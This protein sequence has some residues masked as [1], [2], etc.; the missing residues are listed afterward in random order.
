MKVLYSSSVL[1]SVIAIAIAISMINVQSVLETWWK[2]ASIFRGGM[3]GLFLLGLISKKVNNT[4]AVIGVILGLIVIGWMSLSPF[5]FPG[6]IMEKYTSP[7]H[8]YLSIVFG[9]TTI[10]ITGFLAGYILKN[11]SQ[12]L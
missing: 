9:T 11:P 10:F 7:F 5:L 1:F 4:S 8:S 3:L 2:L 12:Q 6:T